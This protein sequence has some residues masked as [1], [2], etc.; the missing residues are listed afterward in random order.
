MIELAHLRIVSALQQYGTLTKAANA[1]C[2]SQSALSHQIRYLEKKLNVEIWVKE[3]RRLRLTRAGNL[4]LETAQ[5]I[6]PLLQ[7][8]E[9]TLK[10]YAQGKQ[11][12]LRLGVECYPC[13]EWLTGVIAEYLK[14]NPQVDVD[15]FQRFRFSGFEG[16]LNFHIDM[17]ITP[18]RVD[19]PGLVYETLFEYELLLLVPDTHPLVERDWVMPEQLANET[20]IT[21][22]VATERL[23]ILNG[24]LWPAGIK[25]LQHKQIE[26][27]D[28]MLQLV[29]LSRGVTALP[30]WLAQRACQSLPL[31]SLRLGSQGMPRRLYSA[32]RAEDQG[33]AYQQQFISLGKAHACIIGSV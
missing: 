17:L 3:G 30:D 11:G 22:P 29:A 5:K 6:L 25:P 32:Y 2:L 10:A 31:R 13:Y 19:H 23:D 18:D 20:L 7:Q 4:L 28:I 27:I 15:I 16:V 9:R 21:F 26:S 12:I 1:L 14:T 33:V 8:S 24:F